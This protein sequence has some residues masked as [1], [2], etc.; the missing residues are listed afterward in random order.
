MSLRTPAYGEGE[1]LCCDGLETIDDAAHAVRT[2]DERERNRDVSL[3]KSLRR[4]SR[5]DLPPDQLESLVKQIAFG[6]RCFCLPLDLTLKFKGMGWV[7]LRDVLDNPERYISWSRN[8]GPTLLD[9]LE[10]N[11]QGRD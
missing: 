1:P 2:E 7:S 6:R 3:R 10:P 11:E 5:H 4:Y 8:N 9:S